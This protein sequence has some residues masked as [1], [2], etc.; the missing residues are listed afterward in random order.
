MTSSSEVGQGLTLHEAARQL[1]VPFSLESEPVDRFIQANGMNFHY[2]EWG[3][4][5]NPDIGSGQQL[6]RQRATR[7][8]G[9]LDVVSRPGAGTTVELRVRVK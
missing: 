9:T 3:D 1:G 6:M 7:C 5:A 2:L 4:T 8:H